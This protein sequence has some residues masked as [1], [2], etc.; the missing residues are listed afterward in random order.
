MVPHLAGCHQQ[1]E[2]NSCDTPNGAIAEHAEILASE[3]YDD[4]ADEEK[5]K[6]TCG[7]E[8]YRRSDYTNFQAT[9]LQQPFGHRLCSVAVALHIHDVRFQLDFSTRRKKD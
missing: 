8:K 7:A 9:L 6:Q 3:V 1:A 2:P 4:W 5:N